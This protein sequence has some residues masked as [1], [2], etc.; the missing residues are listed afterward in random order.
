MVVGTGWNH[1]RGWLEGGDRYYGRQD[2]ARIIL[3]GFSSWE[4]VGIMFV[5]SMVGKKGIVIIVVVAEGWEEGRN[6][7][8]EVQNR[9]KRRE[10]MLGG[11]TRNHG[12]EFQE[13][14]RNYVCD[15]RQG[16]G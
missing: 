10:I 6:N 13:E 7:I 8:C 12:S 14:A 3:T 9:E 4:K 1:G 2:G 11:D 15:T 5:G 16:R